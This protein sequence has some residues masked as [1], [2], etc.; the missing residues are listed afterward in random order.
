MEDI[1]ID[2][3]NTWKIDLSSKFPVR[4]E[5]YSKWNVYKFFQT[6]RIANLAMVHTTEENSLLYISPAIQ[7]YFPHM[8]VSDSGGQNLMW[9]FRGFAH[10]RS[11][12]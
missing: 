3:S 7:E 2:F 6:F 10:I 4:V 8:S 5:K 12:E 1:F 9:Y 11:N